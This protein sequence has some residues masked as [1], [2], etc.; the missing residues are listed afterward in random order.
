M[1][2]KK[3]LL[4]LLLA[5]VSLS[6]NAQFE[7]GTNYVA[8]RLTGLDLSYSKNS[9]FHFGVEALAGRFVADSWMLTGQFGYNHQTLSGPDENRFDL[10]IG[11]RYYFKQN[12]IYVGCGLLYEFEKINAAKNNSI[13]LTP[14]VGYCFYVNHFLSLE[15]A[16]Y[17]NICL[18]DFS[19]GSKVGLKL[20]LGFYF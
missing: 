13:N 3:T 8:T 16:L 5:M 9:K 17:Y 4:T 11:T 2:T 10:G 6:A 7:K 14:E 20:G 12:G 1:R 19:D 18:N 15:P